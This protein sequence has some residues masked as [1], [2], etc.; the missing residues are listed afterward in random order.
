MRI[1]N[2]PTRCITC[3]YATDDDGAL[4]CSNSKCRYTEIDYKRMM[5]EEHVYK[6]ENRR[7]K[8]VR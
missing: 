8:Q 6:R 2:E 5:E 1:C 7:I 3:I 4:Y